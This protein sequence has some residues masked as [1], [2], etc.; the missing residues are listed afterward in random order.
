[1]IK[2]KG[3]CKSIR[4]QDN[5]YAVMFVAGRMRKIGYLLSVVRKKAKVKKILEVNVYW[6]NSKIFR[7][8]FLYWDSSR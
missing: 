5:E 6:K 8:D 4:R 3:I 7:I 2:R 1:M